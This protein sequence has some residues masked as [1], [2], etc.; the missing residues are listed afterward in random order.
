[1][2]APELVFLGFRLAECSPKPEGWGRSPQTDHV[3]T[4]C[5]ISGCVAGRE[6]S[7]TLNL[8]RANCLN[9]IAEAVAE[10]VDEFRPNP[11]P[12]HYWLCAY[13][14]SPV[15]Y[16]KESTTCQPPAQLFD[17]ALPP[18]PAEPDLSEFTRLG[19]DVVEYITN[20][21]HQGRPFGCSPLFCNGMAELIRVNDYC[22]LPDQATASAVAAR[23]AREEPEP[24]PYLVIEILC[25]LKLSHDNPTP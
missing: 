23:F 3:T 7:W 9:T 24:G 10:G 19:Y 6:W 17:P 15:I 22:L 5:N 20:H 25:N 12:V 11:D 14:A 13:R 16:G 18:L 21:K 8:N 4:P 1:M 2:N